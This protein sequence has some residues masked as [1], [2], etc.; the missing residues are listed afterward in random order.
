MDNKITKNRLQSFLSYEWIKVIIFALVFIVAWEFVYA[1]ISVKPTVGQDFK[2]Y[3]DQDL[4]LPVPWSFSD[5]GY[6]GKYPAFYGNL[7]RK[8]DLGFSLCPD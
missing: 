4:I 5:C 2:F 6:A 1:I 7:H 8:W 3:F